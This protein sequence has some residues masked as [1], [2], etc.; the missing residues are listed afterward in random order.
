[1]PGYL[2]GA[3]CGTLILA[4]AAVAAGCGS[5]SRPTSEDGS[6]DRGSSTGAGGRGDASAA[7]RATDLG[8]AADPDA[9]TPASRP[10]A[11]AAAPLGGTPLDTFDTGVDFGFE[12]YHDTAQTNLADPALV[13]GGGTAPLLQFDAEEGSPSPGSMKI[14]VPYSGA[15]Q[16][17]E[18]QSYVF[19]V[20]QDWSGQTLHARLKVDAGSTFHGFAQLYVDTGVS[21]VAAATA[22]SVAPGS[23]W[24][25]IAMDLDHPLTV[26][27]ADR[28]SAKQVVL[29][30]LQLN[31]GSAGAG[32]GPVTFHV[33]SFTLD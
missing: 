13:D 19:A 33:D 32:A 9:T 28:Y 7:D 8:G 10:L 16:Y 3:T 17:V 20:P 12:P 30:G 1:M 11:D 21:Y 24:Q 18:V 27:A 15:N 25:E 22:V 31:T 5:S 29:Y 4:I 26:A 6:A 23:D 2:N 14:T